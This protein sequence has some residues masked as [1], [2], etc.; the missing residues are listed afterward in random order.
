MAGSADRLALG[1]VALSLS[2]SLSMSIGLWFCLCLAARCAVVAAHGQH[3]HL[4]RR[5]TLESCHYDDDCIENAYCWN[6]EAC[7][8]KDDYIVYKNRTHV[9]CLKVATAIGDPCEADIQCRITFAT[10]S[11]CQRSICQCSDG[12]HYFEGRCYESIGLGKACQSH[13]NCYIKDSYCVTGFCECTLNYHPNPRNDGC[14]PNVELGDKCSKDYECVAENSTC[15]NVCSCRMSHVVSNDGKR[16][17]RAANS[18]GEPCQEDSQ[19]RLFLKDSNCGSN[20]ECICAD[21]FHRSGSECL[22]DVALN[23]R[24][25]SHRECVTD[26]HR[27]SHS[28]QVTNVECLDDVCVC[29]KDYIITE[30]LRDCIP[31]VDSGGASVSTPWKGITRVFFLALLTRVSMF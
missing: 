17:L 1:G 16:C 31:Y 10:Y 15:R 20:G 14:I 2:L 23:A 12:S 4:L 19:C 25:E 7:L 8:C 9:K 11:E 21:K 24:C 18:V 22:K 27:D 28:I 26:R 5:N 3:E 13:R 29:A 30:E 6:Q